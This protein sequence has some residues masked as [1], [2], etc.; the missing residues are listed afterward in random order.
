MN[1]KHVSFRLPPELLERAQ[2]AV[3][4]HRGP[5]TFLSMNVHVE[6]A[7]ERETRRLERE[8]NDGAPFP[9]ARQSAARRR[10]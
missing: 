1:K 2:A 6:R 4:H 9:P 3:D 8:H 10:A 7:L 5:P